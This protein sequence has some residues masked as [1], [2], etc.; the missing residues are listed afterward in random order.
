MTTTPQDMLNET[1][2]QA[3][4]IFALGVALG[5]KIDAFALAVNRKL[6]RLDHRVDAIEKR[7]GITPPEEDEDDDG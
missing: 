5:R 2:A 6:R 1:I 4:L 3:P 7:L